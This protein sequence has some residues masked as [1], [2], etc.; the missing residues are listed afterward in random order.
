MDLVGLTTFLTLVKSRSPQGLVVKVSFSLLQGLE[1]WVWLFGYPQVFKVKFTI[2]LPQGVRT[3][4]YKN[5]NKI[6]KIYG[7][8]IVY[9]TEN[10]VF[11]CHLVFT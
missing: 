1:V 2:G 10:D 11:K 5:F 7:H 6:K 9:G 8:M 4:L 3:K